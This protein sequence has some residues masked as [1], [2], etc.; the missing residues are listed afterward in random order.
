VK[1]TQERRPG[2]WICHKC[3]V[4]NYTSRQQCFKCNIEKPASARSGPMFN[5]GGEM[6]GGPRGPP[7]SG[8]GMYY[9]PNCPCPRCNGPNRGMGRSFINPFRERAGGANMERQ[10][11][12]NPFSSS[13][14]FGGND[15]RPGDWD[16]PSCRGHNYA[17]KK[18]CFRCGIEKPADIIQ[19]R[20][21][22]MGY[23]G[24]FLQRRRNLGGDRRPGDWDCP[25]CNAH[26]YASKTSC[27]I[28]KKPK[29]DGNEKP[30]FRRG[31]RGQDRRP[32][33]WDCPK[34][35]AHNYAD[36]TACFICSVPKPEDA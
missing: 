29:P 20:S 35:Q 4:L 25:A 32:G 21:N 27:F 1:G 5:P 14:P 2:D 8:G 3:N 26:N 30:E 31:K 12:Y 7:H 19:E 17:D 9:C 11:S 15:R 16:C 6:W 34:C 24:G 36:K 18:A 10:E 22:G 33:D 13:G 28:C 23:S